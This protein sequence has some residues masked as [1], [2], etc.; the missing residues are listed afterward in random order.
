MFI[1]L[2]LANSGKRENGR[3]KGG[4]VVN[5]ESGI[6]GKAWQSHM[7]MA[8]VIL[9]HVPELAGKAGKWSASPVRYGHGG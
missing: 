5:P 6:S 9:D 2:V 8:G 1:A 7:A 4:S 3:W